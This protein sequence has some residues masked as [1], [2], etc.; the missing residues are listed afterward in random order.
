MLSKFKINFELTS[1]GKYA[2]INTVVRERQRKLKNRI[3]EGKRVEKENNLIFLEDKTIS[4]KL[5]EKLF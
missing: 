4:E 5:N 3:D 2:I 1:R